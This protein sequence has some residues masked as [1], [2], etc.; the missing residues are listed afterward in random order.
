M[1]KQEVQA[2]YINHWSKQFKT[3]GFAEVLSTAPD[4]PYLKLTILNI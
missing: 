1:R 2:V 3:F 4:L